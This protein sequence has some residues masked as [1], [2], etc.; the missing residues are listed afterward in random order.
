ME[1]F[2]PALRRLVLIVL[3][4]VGTVVVVL[5]VAYGALQTDPGRRA[6]VP[7][8]E[9]GLAA[10]GIEARIDGLA[11]LSADRLRL[12]RLSLLDDGTPWFSAD[13]IDL[14]W[15]PSALLGGRVRIASLA[16]TQAA[17]LRLPPSSGGSPGMTA[18][19]LRLPV[20][21]AIERLSVGT[22]SLDAALLGTPA[23]LGIEGQAAVREDGSGS[24]RLDVVRRDTIGGHLSTHADYALATRK[25]DLSLSLVEPE[26]G[27]LVSLLDVP[28]RPALTAS[29]TGTGSLDGWHGRFAGSAGGVM[30]AGAAIDLAFHN[31]LTIGLSGTADVAQALPSI[32]RGLVAPQVTF[33]AKA[34]WDPATDA[35]HVSA[36]H[37][38]SGA[39]EVTV[40]GTLDGRTLA[41]DARLAVTFSDARVLDPLIAPATVRTGTAT[42][43]VGGSILHPT[44]HIDARLN[45]LS[46]EGM[47]AEHATLA[48]TYAFTGDGPVATSGTAR[49]AGLTGLPAGLVELVGGEVQA[50]WTGRIFTNGDIEIAS[51]RIRGKGGEIAV[52][53]TVAA[54]GKNAELAGSIEVPD[55]AVLESLLATPVRG[56]ASVTAALHLAGGRLRATV[57][58]D[59]RQLVLPGA[60]ELSQGLGP[61]ITLAADVEGAKGSG[62]RFD[63]LTLDAKGLAA[64]GKI[65]FAPGFQRIDGDYRVSLADLA[66][67]SVPL[68]AAVAG[69]ATVT[70]TAGGTLATPWI[71]GRIVSAALQAGGVS[72]RDLGIDYRVDNALT[73]PKGTVTAQVHSPWDA[74]TLRADFALADKGRLAVSHVD[75]ASLGTQ[76]AGA[77]TL[78]LGS[79]LADGHLTGTAADLKPWSAVLGLPMAGTV[80]AK[81]DLHSADGHQQATIGVDGRRLAITPAGKG[82]VTA[83]SMTVTIAVTDLRAVPRIDG[84]IRVL[85]LARQGQRLATL[86]TRLRGGRDGL[87][88]DLSAAGGAETPVDVATSGELAL[89]GDGIDLTVAKLTGTVHGQR[90]ALAGPAAFHRDAG[91]WVAKG[92]ALRIGDGT[93]TGD[94]SLSE[95]RIALD[96]RLGHLS[97]ALV[98]LVWP[99]HPMG[100]IVDGE[101]RL[102][103]SVAAPEGAIRL[104][105]TGATI[106]VAGE[107]LAARGWA[108]GTLTAGEL[109]LKAGIEGPGKASVAFDGRLPLRLSL[110]P[111]AVPLAGNDALAAT[112][113]GG[114]DLA[115]LLG[116]FVPDPHRLAGN[117]NLEVAVSGTMS[118][119]RADGFVQ[120]S[121]GR[122]ENIVTGMVVRDMVLDARVHDGSLDVVQATG[123]AGNGRVSASGRIG[124]TL[125][126][127]FPVDLVVKA[128]KASVAGRDDIRAVASGEIALKGPV[129]ALAITG[130]ATVDDVEASL[131]DRLPPDV[132]KLDVVEIHGARSKASE[133]RGDPAGQAI[134]LDL[135]ITV[136]NRLFV[137]GRGLDSEWNGSLRVSGPMDSPQVAGQLSPVRGQFSFAGKTFALQ[138]GSTVAF[139]DPASLVPVLDIT[140]EYSGQDFTARFTLRGPADDPKLI[141]SSVPELPQDEIVSRL[142]FGRGVARISVVE[143]AQLA[144]AVAS[145]SGRGGLNVLDTARRLLGV[146]VLRVEAGNQ[147]GGPAVTA[148]RYLSKDVYV[149]VSQGTSATSGEAKVE[150]EVTPHITIETEVGP[151]SGGQLGARW[152]YDY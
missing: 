115:T 45:G 87:A 70:G 10:I 93:V 100:G 73:R 133:P 92:V 49:I 61:E 68:G 31:R 122:Y 111:P 51:S 37:F 13:T 23:S 89:K 2:R 116:P 12:A 6:A 39:A 20:N 80:S 118:E 71:K 101:V 94:A 106:G 26:N 11:E 60:G 40:D 48:A 103:G 27:L 95:E 64:S 25:L 123:L 29:L 99:D 82:A 110:D 32:L 47:T 128:D 152:K 19:D 97:L 38:A 124:L 36:A 113:R 72:W 21:I 53:G 55:L 104:S 151:T 102:S 17:L 132:V 46:L 90:I 75:L 148:G 34:A 88:F 109:L 131:V 107:N 24:L 130:R 84:Q 150:V 69:Q 108:E 18:D 66:A 74:V 77:A 136:P 43:I 85:G 120:V 8:I 126:S 143:A 50:D 65:I 134:T 28:G 42:I 62:W 3:G 138:Q 125:G 119:P 76:L 83:D 4:M 127:G 54:L 7:L 81:L 129:E 112:L 9:K 15:H 114:G 147:Q 140:A 91:R 121:G 44:G 22:L 135:T 79:G 30:T 96:V 145:L 5:A 56:G 139:R 98:N 105:T 149:G 57:A 59:V 78:D 137:R 67:L 86:E 41:T 144:D 117:L 142:L 35:V 16:V 52:S 1:R 146:D 58:A 63:N 141:L 33:D 14:A